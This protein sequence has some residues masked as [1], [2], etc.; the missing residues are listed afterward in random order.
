[1]DAGRPKPPLFD[2]LRF[3]RRGSVPWH[4]GLD[5]DVL[6]TEGKALDYDQQHQILHQL[7][8]ALT[9]FDPLER[10]GGRDILEPNVSAASIFGSHAAT[11]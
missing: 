11:P 7:E 3:N 9:S 5:L 1:M 8:P 2:H 10:R 6:V 4:I